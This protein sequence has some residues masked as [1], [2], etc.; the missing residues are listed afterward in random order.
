[1]RNIGLPRPSFSGSEG[2]QLT[3]E[4]RILELMIEMTYASYVINVIKYFFCETHDDKLL[5]AVEDKLGISDNHDFR[6]KFVDRLLL[7]FIGSKAAAVDL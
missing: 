3:Q 4:Q 7:G 2:A 5:V 1:M 6:S